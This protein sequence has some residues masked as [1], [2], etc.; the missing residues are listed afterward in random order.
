VLTKDTSANLK[1]TQWK[2]WCEDL[3]IGLGRLQRESKK[4]IIIDDDFMCSHCVVRRARFLSTGAGTLGTSDGSSCAGA[5]LV[6]RSPKIKGTLNHTYLNGRL[7]PERGSPPPPPL[8]DTHSSEPAAAAPSP[9]PWRWAELQNGDRIELPRRM[10]SSSATAELSCGAADCDTKRQPSIL[11]DSGVELPASGQ[12]G[13]QHWHV[14]TVTLFDSL[15]SPPPIPQPAGPSGA[16]G[17]G[18]GALG[19]Q[20]TFPTSV[21]TD[22]HASERADSGR[23]QAGLP[24]VTAESPRARLAA[25][26]PVPSTSQAPAPA[27]VPDTGIVDLTGDDE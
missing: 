23:A 16:T 25:P 24:D 2:L 19:T 5:V 17:S 12:P 22:A 9:P 4:H 1:T 11:A 8:P 10:A 3:E 13:S 6:D 14:F 15:P 18:D 21:R 7:V 27:E 20:R 26:G